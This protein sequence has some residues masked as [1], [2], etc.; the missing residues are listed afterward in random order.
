MSPTY[1]S[2]HFTLEEATASDTALRLGIDNT[3]PSDKVI[4]S[5]RLTAS[6]L[7]QV[8]AA[9]GGPIDVT[10]WI[11][12]LALNR[13]IGSKD[14]SQHILGE[15]VDFRAPKF[16]TPLAICKHL[17]IFK[18]VL[19]WDQLILEHTWIHISWSSLPNAK[20]CGQVLSLLATGGYAVGLTDPSGRPL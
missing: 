10:S 16:G 1:L 13:A 11:R 4:S 14:T 9:I 6:H 2:P 8:R 7:E 19:G 12:C 15:A 17:I 18:Q 3:H 20:Q 5:A